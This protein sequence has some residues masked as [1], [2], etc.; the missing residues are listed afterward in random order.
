MKLQLPIRKEPK[1]IVPQSAA[2][3]RASIPLQMGEMQKAIEIAAEL[4][5]RNVDRYGFGEEY[6]K[7][8]AWM[9]RVQGIYDESARVIET[10]EL[11]RNGDVI[12]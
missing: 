2:A 11:W 6:N 7:V 8:A 3:Y 4:L 9:D 12:L 5:K 1:Q 10:G